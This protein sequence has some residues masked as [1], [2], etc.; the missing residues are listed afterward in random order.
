[1]NYKTNNTMAIG[2]IAMLTGNVTKIPALVINPNDNW[3]KIYIN[4][5][6]VVNLVSAN[7]TYKIYFEI[8]SDEGV[9]YPV[10]YIDNIKLVYNRP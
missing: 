3:N 9:T 4:L 8:A 2:V 6:N 1:M 7:C 10:T 5:T